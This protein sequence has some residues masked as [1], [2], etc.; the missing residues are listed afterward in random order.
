M[1]KNRVTEIKCFKCGTV[2][3]TA[4]INGEP[5]HYA[6]SDPAARATLPHE[7]NPEFACEKC[8]KEMADCPCCNNQDFEIFKTIFSSF[9]KN[10]GGG[11]KVKGDKKRSPRTHSSMLAAIAEWKST[12]KTFGNTRRVA[13]FTRGLKNCTNKNNDRRRLVTLLELSS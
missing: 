11:K 10:A 7:K 3:P 6:P 1:G 5:Y 13:R 2:A 9:H 8:C 4:S 12:D